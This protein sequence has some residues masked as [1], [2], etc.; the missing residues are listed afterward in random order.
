MIKIENPKLVIEIQNSKLIQIQN[1][2]LMIRIRN[3]KSQN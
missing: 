3:S 2:K 1:P